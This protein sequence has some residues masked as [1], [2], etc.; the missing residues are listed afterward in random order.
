MKKKITSLL[1]TFAIALTAL[2]GF[3]GA[4]VATAEPAE[5]R[6]KS[7][8]YYAHKYFAIGNAYYHAY[9]KYCYFSYSWWEEVTKGMEDG[10]YL[11]HTVWVYRYR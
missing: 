2:V 1:A 5:A 6:T 3:T 9:N 8:C 11:D 7:N 10:W 4:S